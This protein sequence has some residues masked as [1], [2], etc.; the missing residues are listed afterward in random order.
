MLEDIL[1]T[2]ADGEEDGEGDGSK[3][4][5][6]VRLTLTEGEVVD[7]D[8]GKLV[9]GLIVGVMLAEGEGVVIAVTTV[10]VLSDESETPRA[11]TNPTMESSPRRI[12]PKLISYPDSTIA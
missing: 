6:V 11:P 3:D 7:T 2:H 12:P 9:V 8:Y 1:L 10:T 5:E 4:G